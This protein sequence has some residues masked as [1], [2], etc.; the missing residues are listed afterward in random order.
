MNTLLE[1]ETLLGNTLLKLGFITQEELTE[2]LRLKNT[3]L[4]TKE[5]RSKFHRA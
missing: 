5:D 2:A 4:R 3:T 1:D